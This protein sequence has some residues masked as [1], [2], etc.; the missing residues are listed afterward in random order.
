MLT[1]FSL[2]IGYSAI[3]GVKDGILWGKKGADSFKWNEHIVFFIERALVG[4]IPLCVP[5]LKPIAILDSVSLIVCFLMCFSF[6]HNGFYYECR[7]RIDVKNYHWF[8]D[9]RS[10]TA[11]FEA[12]VAI[13]TSMFAVGI[14][15]LALSIINK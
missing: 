14:I 1:L 15:I 6:V 8:F 7:K 5:F 12:N 3:S 2:L 11:W 9:S 13:R 4:A 10:S